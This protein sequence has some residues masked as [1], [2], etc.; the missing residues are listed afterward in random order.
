MESIDFSYPAW[1][2]LIIALLAIIIGGI[3]Y[4]K[5]Q[6]NNS[7]KLT[8]LLYVLRGMAAFLILF[9][10]LNPFLSQKVNE[11]KK[12]KVIF[13]QDN[14]QSIKESYDSIDLQEFVKS[15]KDFFTNLGNNYGVETYSFGDE[16]TISSISNDSFTGQATNIFDALKYIDKIHQTDHIGAIVLAS[17]GIYNRGANPTYFNSSGNTPIFTIAMGD[18]TVRQDIRIKQILYNEIVRKDETNEI[19]I[20]ITGNYQQEQPLTVL[21]QAYN[22]TNWTTIDRKVLNPGQGEIFESLTFQKTYDTPGIER[23]RFVVTGVNNDPQPANNTREFFVEVLETTRK[24]AV[25]SSAPHPDIGVLQNILNSKNNKVEVFLT[26]SPADFPS[27]KDFDLFIFYQ[28]NG[29]KDLVSYIESLF[30][31]HKSLFFITGLQTSY[32]AFNSIQDLM[33]INP[34]NRQENIFD[35]QFS[36]QFDYFNIDNDIQSMVKNYPPLTG[37]FGDFS[38][39]GNGQ[40]LLNQRIGD[41]ETEYP[42]LVMGQSRG[43]RMAILTGEGIWKW[44]LFEYLETQ[45]NVILTRFFDKIIE[46]IGQKKD[47]RLFRLQ[48]SKLL[49]D[50]TEEVT[51]SAELYNETLER[52]S[53]PDVTFELIDSSGN[54]SH[55]TFDKMGFQYF[56]NLG[57]LQPGPYSY[58]ASTSTAGENYSEEGNFSVR[59]IQLESYN[60]QANHQL[61]KTIATQNDG[62]LFYSFNELADTIQSRPSMNSLLVESQV[63]NSMINWKLLFIIIAG[64]IITEWIIRRYFGGY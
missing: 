58:K 24:I 6:F 4:F 32:A 42:A 50:E 5:K 36:N 40:V 62:D 38:L 48:K 12:A 39:T 61:L 8:I 30:D 54:R 18:T 53:E 25:I 17:D 45:D 21:F 15:S 41:V 31:E 13:L 33:A 22:N 44:K 43:T 49:F 63:K 9:L 46:Y 34:K 20:D 1:T 37:V 16:I 35:I 59:D 27:I 10:L 52:I 14:S 19:E 47:D 64:L 7:P 2:L 11:E 23:L 56:L 57:K 3:A 51:F 55:F 26:E 60:L 29:K 28:I